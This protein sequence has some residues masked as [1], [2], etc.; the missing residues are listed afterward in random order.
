MATEDNVRAFILSTVSAASG[1]TFCGLMREPEGSYPVRAV[2]VLQSGGPAPHGYMDG[3]DTDYRYERVQIRVRAEN[4][5]YVT[6]RDLAQSIWEVCQRGHQHGL[7]TAYVRCTA[8]QSAPMY[9]GRD[10][11]E[12]HEW[13]INVLLE[14]EA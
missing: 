10:E 14:K 1:R 11:K 9:W 3:Q 13:S 5:A 8:S 12:R 6:G 4:D 2:S 7:T